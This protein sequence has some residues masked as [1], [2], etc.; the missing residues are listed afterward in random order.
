MS[1]A[2][3]SW[4]KNG[5]PREGFTASSRRPVAG[6]A[7]CR[8]MAPVTEREENSMAIQKTISPVD[9]SVYVEREQADP[10]LIESTLADCCPT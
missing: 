6:T 5:A 1:E 3:S 8:S 2:H 4:M 10:A 7:A 9:G